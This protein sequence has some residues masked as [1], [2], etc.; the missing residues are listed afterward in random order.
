MIGS[1]TERAVHTWEM[2]VET[3]RTSEN[4]CPSAH[5]TLYQSSLGTE[6]ERQS[7]DLAAGKGGHWQKAGRVKTRSE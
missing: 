7:R 3:E 2:V 5:G 1:G 4:H 6:G